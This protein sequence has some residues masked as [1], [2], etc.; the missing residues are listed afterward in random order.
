V[1]I[2]RP[3]S[4][5]ACLVAALV[6]ARSAAAQ[7]PPRQAPDLLLPVTTEVVRIDV[8]VTEKGGRPRPGLS[9]DDF[10][11][12][13][14]G[15]PQKIAQFEAFTAAPAR[16]LP[17]A[18]A[19]ARAE[20]DVEADEIAPER[21]IP[22]RR[23]VVLA[24]DDVHIEAGNLLR[25]K[26]ALDRFLER[27]IGPEDQ[28]AIVT[29][30]GTRGIYQEFTDDRHVLQRSVARLSVQDRTLQAT[31][32]PYVTEYQ[33]E[34][35]ERGDTEALRV[36]VEEVMQSGLY[37]D[38]GTAEPVARAAAHAVLA[39]SI[40]NGRLTLETLDAVVRNLADLRGRK[41]VALVSDGFLTGL[42]VNSGS[43][44]DIRRISDAATRAGVV[45]YSLDTRGLVASS[46]GRSASSRMP[47]MASTF[48]ARDLMLRESEHATREAMSAL[49]GDTGGFLVQ[50]TNDLGSG[51]RKIL[52]D[53]ETYYLIAYES[54]NPKRDGAFRKLE[55]RLPGQREAR[56]RTRKGYFAPDDRKLKATA[57]SVTAA[58]LADPARRAEE[59]RA[60][61]MKTALTS[62]VL[63]DGIPV[64]LSA[65]FV[66]VDGAAPQVVVSS[67]VD[68]K[69]VAFE[70]A[71]ERHL[72]TV[73]AAATVFDESG[74]V[75]GSL[76]PE[77]AA[78][79]LTDASY[80]KALQKGLEYQKAAPVKPGRYRVR[81]AVRE[82]GGGKLG[83]ASQWVRIPDLATGKLTLSSLF[84][85]EKD[86][87]GES[88]EAAKDD[89]VSLRGVQ[90]RRRFKQD[91][92]LYVQLYAYNPGRDAAGAT[93]LATQAEIWRG[94]ALLASSSSESMVPGDRGGA[95]VPHTRSIKLAPFGPGDY[96][97]R[98]VVT[99]SMANEMRSRRAAFTIE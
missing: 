46:P 17:T 35:I 90:A 49:S 84:L 53:T 61:E 62:L 94:G 99:D 34:Q 67:H 21:T 20:A 13:E 57:P 47:V 66:S 48:S 36:A 78:M 98:I 97:V 37:Q 95:P 31:G 42:T 83:T 82:D 77:R 96:E 50:D 93:S 23:Y 5:G 58:A 7:T 80:E 73:D 26:K 79:D 4:Y 22:P 89:A 40:N 15:Q 32:A 54:T 25:I 75:V 16:A 92:T 27:E 44:F 33:A 30:S 52:K 19:P 64:R 14:D 9:Q 3:G 56:I 6:A 71:G 72:A 91:A 39:E 69:G 51:L 45:I 76:A 68:L 12:L 81:M 8:V 70:H 60:S 63:Q 59:R 29:T 18:S 86:V 10:V 11:V 74:A 28:V 65:D 55:V 38:A 24:V 88:T 43:G 87:A 1:R 41:V 2:T 85:L